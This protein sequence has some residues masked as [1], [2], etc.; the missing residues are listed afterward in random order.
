MLFKNVAK[1]KR[2]SNTNILETII[3]DVRI[4]YMERLTYIATQ[5][6]LLNIVICLNP[7]SPNFDQHQI[8]SCITNAYSTCEVMRIK[9]MITQ[10]EFFLIYQ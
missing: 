6:S 7:L 9:D 3:I 4:I 1:K 10:G 5:V 2:N 8:S